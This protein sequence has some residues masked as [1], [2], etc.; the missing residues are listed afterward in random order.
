MAIQQAF[1]GEIELS[2]YHMKTK[3]SKPTIYTIEPERIKYVMIEKLYENVQ[4]LPTIY[5]SLNLRS[6]IYQ[7]VID[8]YETSEFLL[9]I[10]KKNVM[11]NTSIYT[12]VVKDTFSY[13]SSSTGTDYAKDIVSKGTENERFR[14]II[15]GLV[16]KT[17]TADLRKP[18]GGENILYNVTQEKLVKTALE[19]LPNQVVEPLAYNKTFKNLMVPPVPSRYKFLKFL[20]NR[21]PF[22]D[23]MFTFF[24]DFK[25]TYL[26]SKNG[27][28]T[29]GRDGKPNN[30]MINVKEFTANDAYKDGF[31]IRNDGYVINVNAMDT[32]PVI[33]DSLSKVQTNIVAYSDNN[34][35]QN[36]STSDSND[37]LNMYIR[38][39]NA[40]AM[41]NEISNTKY[42]IEL[43][44]Q[45]VDC[46]IFTPNKQYLVSN[47]GELSKY[48][49]R[50]I[51]SY[52]KEFYYFTQ[53]NQFTITCNIGLK[54]TQEEERAMSKEDHVIPTTITKGSK[55]KKTSTK[56]PNSFKTADR[57][58]TTTTSKTS[59]ATRK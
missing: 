22:Y 18:F 7:K 16:S 23:S 48:D 55:V 29:P 28:G 21:K 37:T 24:M 14:G 42:M 17:M 51:L 35:V 5:I 47:Y 19:G 34:G 45:N 59:A 53:G 27:I 2:F 25:N 6:D 26:V 32:N 41:K 38:S 9:R 8:T 58:S 52:K 15:L 36:L 4:I 39:D 33:N 11:S 10:R 12:E 3:D 57:K 31:T 1:K 46:E 20:F 13:V 49:G 50:Y 44:K 40:A 30:I 56:K 43:L 54:L